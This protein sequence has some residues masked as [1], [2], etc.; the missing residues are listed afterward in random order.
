MIAFIDDHR[1]VHGAHRADHVVHQPLELFAAVTVAIGV[2]Q[3][4]RLAAGS[5]SPQSLGDQLCRHSC[6]HRP[7]DRGRENGSITPAT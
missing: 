6:A 3:E 4:R 2:M 1:G 7:A 5:P